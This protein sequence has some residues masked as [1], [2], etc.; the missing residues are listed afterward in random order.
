[1]IRTSTKPRRPLKRSWIRPKKRVR[2]VSWRTGRIREDAAG[3]A[4]LRSDAFHRSNGICEC[5]R[6]VCKKRTTRERLVTWLDGQLH[7]VISRAHGGSDVLDNVQF[8]T[9]Q[10]HAEI[11][12]IPY[13]TNW[14]AA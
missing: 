4:R 12:G 11:T 13:W 7:H 9:R 3:M 6:K 14:K 8:V 5:G 10:C 2:K 1:M